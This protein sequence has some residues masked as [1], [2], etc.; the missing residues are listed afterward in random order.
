MVSF[1]RQSGADMDDPL[2]QAQLE[3]QWAKVDVFGDGSITL[4]EFETMQ[5]PVIKKQAKAAQARREAKAAAQ[6][7]REAKRAAA[8]AAAAAAAETLLP[9]LPLL[10]KQ[11]MAMMA[12][13]ACQW[14][15]IPQSL[16]CGFIYLGAPVSKAIRRV[17]TGGA[18]RDREARDA[19]RTTGAPRKDQDCTL[20]RP[21]L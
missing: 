4:L 11:M 1:Y 13:M 8:A 14:L 15:C 20:E 6:A 18:S 5:V 17:F 9:L 7:K 2:V 16:G 19:K 3:E 21:A 12:M 10:P